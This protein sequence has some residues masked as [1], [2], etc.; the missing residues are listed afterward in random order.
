MS[1]SGLS[2]VWR[3][4][5]LLG[6]RIWSLRVVFCVLRIA[7][8][9]LCCALGVF[10]FCCACNIAC[11]TLH[12][13]CT[14]RKVVR[15][16]SFWDLPK[17]V[18]KWSQNT[19][20]A[21]LPKTVILQSAKQGLYSK[22]PIRT[23]MAVTRFC[24]VWEVSKMVVLGHVQKW[25]ERC[26][27]VGATLCIARAVFCV[28]RWVC[29]RCGNTCMFAHMCVQ[30]C[31][32]RWLWCTRCT[33]VGVVGGVTPGR[34]VG[35]PWEGVWGGLAPLG[36]VYGHIWPYMGVCTP[37]Q[38]WPGCVHVHGQYACG[39]VKIWQVVA[40]RG[41]PGGGIWPDMAILTPWEGS[42]SGHF[43]HFGSYMAR[44]G[45]FGTPSGRSWPVS[46]AL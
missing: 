46:T 12:F 1:K 31:M 6:L 32:C 14:V 23:V 2:G 21:Y 36:G 9:V 19:T 34:V 26:L 27:A 22:E 4:G 33:C 37:V 8:G 43:G 24:M 30:S 41:W 11:A 45:H 20:F 3:L 35:T 42:K 17:V 39:L 40:K 29:L 13:A 28:A 25:P 10:V 18:P 5:S 44:Y 38:G 7:R 16:W 15:K